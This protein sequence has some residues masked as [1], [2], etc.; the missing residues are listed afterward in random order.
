[1]DREANQ[2][3]ESPEE[4]TEA[5]SEALAEFIHRATAESDL[6]L[7][8]LVG[9]KLVLGAYGS[10]EVWN[11]RN[12]GA[13]GLEAVAARLRDLDEQTRWTAM[14]LYGCARFY[15]Q[16]VAL[17]VTAIWPKLVYSHFRAV[18]GLSWDEQ[19]QM[20]DRAQEDHWSAAELA[21]KAAGLRKPGRAEELKPSALAAKLLRRVA[22]VV[23]DRS[24]LAAELG[25]AGVS[26]EDVGRIVDLMGELE[27]EVVA[28]RQK[29]IH[30]GR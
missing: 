8:R 1:M 15:E 7:R 16:T 19:R 12:A 28:V 24:E 29:L 20:L 10:L 3:S 25:R 11:R 30:G 21:L 26:P 14:Q 6:G 9:E 18:Q 22:G 23:D 2:I 17:D 4:L 5:Q 27:G 13:Q